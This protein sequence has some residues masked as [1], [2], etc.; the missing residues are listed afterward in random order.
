MG[1]SRSP[2]APGEPSRRWWGAACRGV[3]MMIAYEVAFRAL[4]LTLGAPAAAWTVGALVAR[5]GSAALSNTAIA[6]FLLTPAG[7]A[8]ALLWVLGYLLG[9]LLL[10]AGLI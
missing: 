9:Q 3:P 5:S 6:R 4:I 1:P 7:L 8:V 10:S 2:T